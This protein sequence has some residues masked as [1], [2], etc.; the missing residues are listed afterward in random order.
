MAIPI[1]RLSDP[2]SLAAC[3]SLQ[4]EILGERART[5]W[6]VPAL[7]AVT[8]SGGWVLAAGAEDAGSSRLHGTLVDLVAEADGYPARY[9]AFRAV[10]RDARGCGVAQ[11]L[12]HAERTLC[13][14]AGVDLAFWAID[15]LR[16]VEAHLAMNKLGAIATQYRRDLFGETPDDVNLG[17]ATDRLL[18]EWWIDAPR[19]V[20]IL[21]RGSP[22]PHFRLG[23]HE[24]DVFTRTHLSA[25]GVRML[26]GHEDDPTGEHVLVEVPA[27]L[28]RIR[29]LDLVAAREWRVKSR[30]VFELLF[31]SGYVGT[32]FIHEGGRSF[33]LFR[34]A[35]RR[36][37]LRDA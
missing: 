4:R 26:V 30:E 16:S 3:V 6:A 28:D 7:T 23:I 17:L 8:E 14:R 37:V 27:D 15:P 13:Q 22:P 2:S 24:M 11:A 35:D 18:I 19:V 9:T 5:V 36:T 20:A 10:S 32:G 34:R 1:S 31:A 29:A 21:D 12:R 33:H 25:N